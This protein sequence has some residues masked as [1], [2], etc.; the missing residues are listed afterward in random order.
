MLQYFMFMCILVDVSSLVSAI[1]IAT[2]FL[3]VVLYAINNLGLGKKKT[4]HLKKPLLKKFAA[5]F[6]FKY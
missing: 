4:N 5:K 1:S 6:C 3:S 2:E